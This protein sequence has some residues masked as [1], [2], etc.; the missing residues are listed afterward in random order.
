VSSCCMESG[1]ECPVAVWRVAQSVQL[2]YGEWHRV[3]QS[4]MGPSAGAQ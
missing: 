2:L 1:T 4:G 3:A